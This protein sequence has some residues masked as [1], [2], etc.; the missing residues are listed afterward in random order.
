MSPSVGVLLSPSD[1]IKSPGSLEP[2]SGPDDSGSGLAE[3]AGRLRK[4]NLMI[5]IR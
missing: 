1:D 4:K 5:K 2:S 3:S